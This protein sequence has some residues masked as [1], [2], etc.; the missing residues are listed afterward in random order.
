MKQLIHKFPN[1]GLQ[2]YPITNSF[3]VLP[4]ITGGGMGFRLALA[5]ANLTLFNLW[6][7]VQ[8]H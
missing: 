2:D 6:L 4:G 3:H 5:G 1:E 7:L 8:N